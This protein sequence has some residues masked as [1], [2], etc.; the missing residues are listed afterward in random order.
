MKLIQNIIKKEGEIMTVPECYKNVNKFDVNSP[1]C[2]KCQYGLE[3]SQHRLNYLYCK[4][5]KAVK[6]LKDFT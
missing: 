2:F 1:K 5:V 4:V 3:C 6:E